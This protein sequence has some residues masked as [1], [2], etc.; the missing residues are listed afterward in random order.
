MRLKIK[1]AAQSLNTQPDIRWDTKQMYGMPRYEKRQL[2]QALSYIL[3]QHYGQ[4]VT[5]Q[6]GEMHGIISPLGNTEHHL[7]AIFNLSLTLLTARQ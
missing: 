6:H 4:Y 3:V 7:Q 5:L 2:L 1:Q